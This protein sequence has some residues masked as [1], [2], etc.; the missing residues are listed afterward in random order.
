MSRDCWRHTERTRVMKRPTKNR[1][2]VR[3][4]FTFDAHRSARS[5]DLASDS[6]ECVR[7]VRACTRSRKGRF[8][9][10]FRRIRLTG[11]RPTAKQVLWFTR[12][13][14][15]KASRG[16]D[17]AAL[18]FRYAHAQATGCERQHVGTVVSVSG[19]RPFRHAVTSSKFHA[20]ASTVSSFTRVQQISTSLINLKRFSRNL[21]KT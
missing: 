13:H 3:P 18:N 5:C 6:C 15:F 10:L 16:R 9:V 8:Y 21:D 7:R 2:R 1:R 12:R 19:S 17:T 11:R 4:R 14:I 20:V